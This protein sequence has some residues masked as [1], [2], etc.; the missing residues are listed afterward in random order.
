VWTGVHLEQTPPLED[1]HIRKVV[2]AIDLKPEA[3]RVVQWAKQIA[4][5]YQARLHVVH[6]TPAYETR[7]ARY[8]DADLRAHWQPKPTEK[9]ES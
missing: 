4:A 9:S 3:E 6:A 8:L 1:L 2:C 5:E 7:P